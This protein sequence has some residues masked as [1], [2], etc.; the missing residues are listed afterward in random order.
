MTVFNS[1]MPELK[2]AGPFM[3]GSSLYLGTCHKFA[4]ICRN[5]QAHVREFSGRHTSRTPKWCIS[6]PFTGPSTS[7]IR[8]A[9]TRKFPYIGNLRANIL[10]FPT[11]KFG[12]S[13]SATSTCYQVLSEV[14]LSVRIS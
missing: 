4:G 5:M 10:E 11:R 12:F 7:R 2:L 1:G 3:F 6:G 13:R 14:L 9:N 8:V